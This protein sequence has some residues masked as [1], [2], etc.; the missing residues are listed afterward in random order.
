MR[1][2]IAA[3]YDVVIIGSGISGLICAIELAKKNKSVCII[4]KEAVTESSSRYAQ[5]GIAVPLSKLDSVEK[6][7]NDTLKVGGG[8]CKR[9]VAK[10][11]INNSSNAFEKLIS[12]GVNFDLTKESAIHQSREAAHSVARVCHVGGDASGRYITKTL[13][14]RACREPKIS[15]SQ[16]TVALKVFKDSCSEAMGVLVED[17]TRDKYVI[18]GMDVIIA[19]GGAGQL[20]RNTTNPN[21][22]TGDGLMIAYSIGAKIQDIEMIQFHPTVFLG[23]G[24]LLLIT[25]AIRGEGG[26]LRNTKGEYFASNYHSMAEL[27]PRDILARAILC[28]LERTNSRFVYLDISNFNE[29]YFKNRFPTIYQFCMERKIDLFKTGIPVSPAAHY[30]IGGIKTDISARTNISRLWAVGEVASNGF[31]GANRLAS[32]SLLECIV[33]PHFLVKALVEQEDISIPNIDSIDLDIDKNNYSE[34]EIKNIICDLQCKNTE[35]LGLARSETELNE[36]LVWLSKQLKEFNLDLPSINYQAQELKNM[37]LLSSFIC[38]AALERKHSIGVHFRKDFQSSPDDFKH[39]VIH[40]N[41]QLSWEIEDSK[42]ELV[43][44]LE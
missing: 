41:K 44:F 37:I 15:I 23:N 7:L 39:S 13:I 5:G 43:S 18:L 17:V 3:K 35:N 36:H 22:S 14:D 2:N 30:F 27:A 42:R 9:D 40:L 1:F 19:T 31:H 26:R 24:E 29:D 8:L 21:V 38:H 12:Y 32:N 25:E 20:Y 6:H 34:D 28:E 10:E 11:I 4:T 33:T 16:G